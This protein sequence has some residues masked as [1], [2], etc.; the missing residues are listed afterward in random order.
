MGRERISQEYVIKVIMSNLCDKAKICIYL[1]ESLS[2][3]SANHAVYQEVGWG[4]EGKQNV[5]HEAEND[6][7]RGESTE[8]C[9]LTT[10]NM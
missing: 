6:D 3:L 2:K 1:D 7:P 9:V 4:V 10:E 8:I 5:G